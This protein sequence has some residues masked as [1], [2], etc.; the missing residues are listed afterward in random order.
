MPID[1][2][3]A[4]IGLSVVGGLLGSRNAGAGQRVSQEAIG[5]ARQ[6]APGTYFNPY[7]VRTGY[8]A[9]GYMPGN[10]YGNLS[11]AYGPMQ[12]ATSL[13]ATSMIPE[14]VDP[15]AVTQRQADIFADTSAQL[16]PAFEQ[17]ATALQSKLFG[18]GRLGLRL[19][20]ESQGLGAGSGMVQPDALGLGRAQQQTL[21][22][23]NTQARQQALG[24]QAQRVALQQGLFGQ[25]MGL[26]GLENQL[27]GLGMSAEQMR[28]AAALGAGQLQLSPYTGAISAANAAGANQANLFGGI[29]GGMFQN[30]NFMASTPT[31]GATA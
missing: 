8:G 17:Q 25:A 26:A 11:G 15:S 14:L 12:G 10:V 24:E 28:A 20:G 9:G 30:P 21:A 16:T 18:G 31:T 19:A 3:T 4:Q 5:L 6:L 27:A 2:V 22:Q 29:L 23:L 7:T 1:P 13:A